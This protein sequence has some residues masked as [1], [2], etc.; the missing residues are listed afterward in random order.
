[1][2]I[3]LVI[4]AILAY[5]LW[6]VVKGMMYVRDVRRNV[7]DAFEQAARG[8]AGNAGG[9]AKPH[10]RKK[11]IDKDV[12]EYVEYEE[13]SVASSTYRET[14]EENDGTRRRVIETESQIV[15]AEWEEVK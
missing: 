5:L 1:M 6:P 2:F 7:R 12:G 14:V 15:D 13:I 9:S 3:F 10:R 8:G 11:K 4:V